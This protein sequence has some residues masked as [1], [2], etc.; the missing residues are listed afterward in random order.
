M[1]SDYFKLKEHGTD[2][3][4]EIIAGFTTFITMSYIIFVNPLFLADAGIP[5]E[6]AVG[7]TIIA[8]AFATILMGIY[9]N[10][11]VAL[12]PGMGLNAFFTYTIVIGMGIP[13]E[14]ALGAVFISG[15][16]FLILTISNIRQAIIH[17]VPQ[18]LRSAIGAGIGLFIATIGLRNA[19]LIVSN[20]DTLVTLGD[21]SDPSVQLV[22]FGLVFT[23]FLITKKI[24]GAFLIGVITTTLIAMIFNLNDARLPTS[25]ANIIGTPPSIAPTL[26]K[27][28]I[29]GAL[30]VGLITVIFSFT[31]VDLFDTIGTFMG[32]TNK[33]GLMREDGH[34]PGMGRALTCDAI[35]TIFGA[36][37]GTS[38]TT[39][40][41][42]SASGIEE[43]GRT[44]LTSLVTGI[45]FLAALFFTP[46]VT[47]VPG[48]AT[49]PIL[50][51]VGVLMIGDIRNINFDDFT[52]AFPAFLTIVLMPLTSSIA[53][54]I[55][56]GFTG[57]AI[58]KTLAG[59]T[60]EVGLVMYLLMILFIIQF[61][62]FRV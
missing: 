40:Y 55:A 28:D 7:A 44:G 4:T 33:A 19:G 57:Y 22:L 23:G 46:L 1:L 5:H 43:G 26:L 36:V 10:F 50:V 30:K 8:S 17:A 21:L 59:R 31:F 45:L 11:P 9:A 27:L 12:A 34:V 62:Y 2:V 3:R 16:I 37:V 52:E 42:E 32:V 47:S 18:S 61:A 56:F 14:T 29:A 60:R 49:A 24:R 54:G 39:S 48:I 25:A 53:Q 35:G 51:L 15:I 20:P 13:W 6:A 58:V 38:T 41:I